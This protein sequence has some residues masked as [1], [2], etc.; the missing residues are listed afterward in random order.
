MQ[1]SD[2]VPDISLAR[3]SARQARVNGDL[4]AKGRA[5]V[6][7]LAFALHLPLALQTNFLRPKAVF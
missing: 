3:T 5:G 7:L 6:F 1:T 2:H 4:R